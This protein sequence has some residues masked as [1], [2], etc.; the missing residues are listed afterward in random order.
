VWTNRPQKRSFCHAPTSRAA[1][2]AALDAMKPVIF[3]IER[4]KED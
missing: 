1:A 2:R 3:K 4:I